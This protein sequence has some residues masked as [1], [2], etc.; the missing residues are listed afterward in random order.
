MSAQ[1]GA[2]AARRRTGATPWMAIPALIFFGIFAVLPL[3]AVVVLSFTTWDGLGSPV[4][5]GAGNWS[6]VVQDPVL[7][8]AIWLS[9]L[10]V[11]GSWL[12]Q[13]PISLLLGVF[14]AGR[15]RYR[16]VLAVLY[17]LPLLFSSAAVAIAFRSLLDPNFGLGAAS[18][19]GFLSQNWLGD[20][21]LAIGVVLFV[22]AW[23]F[24]PLHSLLYQGGVRQ[25]PAELYEAARID[26]AGTWQMFWHITLPQLR[27]TIVTSSILILVGSLTYFDLVYVL[28]QG[29]PGTATRILPL[30]MYLTGFRN[31]DMG[32]A[33]VIATVLVVVGLTI[34]LLLSRLTRSNRME[35][36]QEGL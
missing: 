36:Q 32:A 14:M 10:V 16:N 20:P 18:G 5:T 24:I 17:F 19:L 8:N 31:F 3:G 26:G 25:I 11:A 33:S 28:T 22:I 15:Q 6:R 4:L 23:C 30:H 21:T 9:L 29:G 1:V 35:S 27:Y 13:T 7:H 34:S 12:I 2:G